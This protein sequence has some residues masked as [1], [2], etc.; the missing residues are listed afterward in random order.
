M[1]LRK[2]PDNSAA[3]E[4]VQLE[5][6]GPVLSQALQALIAGSEEHGGV[7]KYAEALK[8]KS[9]MFQ[10]ALG[11]GKIPSLDLD[12]LMGLC[13][14]MSTVRR[15]IAPYLDPTGLAMIKDGLA[16][17][18][19]NMQDT[20]TTD[21]R[22]SAFCGRFPGDKKHRW[23]RDLAG[24]VLAQPRSRALSPDGAVGV[25]CQGQHRCGA[26][27]LVRR[28]CRSHDDTGAGCLCDIRCPA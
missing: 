26:G 22:W 19:D 15:R 3:P 21:V 27:N 9:A 8:L 14:F 17:L 10:D 25:G 13:T 24:E 4:R 2:M 1:L 16:E 23:V 18:T 5:L 6:S 11:D 20:T 28:Q 7:E 12:A